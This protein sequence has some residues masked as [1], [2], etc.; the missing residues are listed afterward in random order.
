ML[1]SEK[2]TSVKK[3][4]DTTFVYFIMKYNE[5]LSKNFKDDKYPKDT[6]YQLEDLLKGSEKPSKKIPNKKKVS[7]TIDSGDDSDEEEKK[8][9]RKKHQITLNKD[10]RLIT[11]FIIEEF[12]KEISQINNYNKNCPETGFADVKEY[13]L[14]E[15]YDKFSDNNITRLIIYSTDKFDFEKF[16][17]DNFD[18]DYKLRVAYDSIV[19]NANLSN[20]ASKCLTDL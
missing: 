10:T 17:P 9:E 5:M 6:Y 16:I 3:E 1:I 14:N 20:V 11:G 4:V 2:L 19:K 8:E 13:I 12:I 15:V 7:D 18:M